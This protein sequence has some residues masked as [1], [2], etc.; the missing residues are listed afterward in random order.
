MAAMVSATQCTFLAGAAKVPAARAKTTN[1]A[2]ARVTVAAPVSINFTSSAVRASFSKQ[3]FETLTVAKPIVAG[4][5]ANALVVL[6][7]LAGDEP[8]K[9]FDFNLTLPII[10]FEFLALMVILDKTIFGPVGKALDDRDELIR[11]QLASVGDNSSAV[12]A[13]IAEKEKLISKARGE[14]ASEVAA[15]KAKSDADIAAAT[16]KAKAVVDVQ[17]AAA[18]KVLEAAKAESASQVDSQAK[19][20]ADQIVKKVVEV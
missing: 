11:S 8:G 1:I 20:I 12:A 6:P 13:L 19:A 2:R 15:L 7:S 9:I 3:A 16:A 5:V 18:L 17:I 14:V 10:A 4:V